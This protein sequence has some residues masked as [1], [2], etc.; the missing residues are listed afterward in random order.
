MWI[1]F[2]FFI[3]VE[4]KFECFVNDRVVL[5]KVIKFVLSSFKKEIF[6]IVKGVVGLGKLICLKYVDEYYRGKEWEV[7]WKEEIIILCDF[8]V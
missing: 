6:V 5:I 1:N 7:K 4:L 8:Y 2:C 3:G